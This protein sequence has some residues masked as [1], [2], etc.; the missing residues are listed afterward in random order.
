MKPFQQ[1]EYIV[2]CLRESGAMYEDDARKFLAEHDAR[3][4]A[5]VLHAAADTLAPVYGAAAMR[6]RQLADAEGKSSRTA[7]ATPD[8]FQPGHT[9]VKG[10]D[11]YKA[12]EQTWTFRCVAVSDHPREGA[13][14]RAFG[15]MRQGIGP[16]DSSA[17][18][19]GEYERGWTD[20]TEGGGRRG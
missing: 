5:E 1:D 11:G 7:D 12:P 17:V 6:L 16:W 2:Q 10:Q 8:F 19:E 3:V 15:F 9:Y 18:R 14:R 20:V 4:R 13:G